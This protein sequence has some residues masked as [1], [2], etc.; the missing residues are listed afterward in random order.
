MF[1]QYITLDSNVFSL[2]GDKVAQGVLLLAVVSPSDREGVFLTRGEIEK[3]IFNL[4]SPDSYISSFAL[5]SSNWVFAFDED[6]SGKLY[7][8]GTIPNTADNINSDKYPTGNY[9]YVYL[10]PEDISQLTHS[11]INALISL[12]DSRF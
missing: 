3:L 9:K 12:E 6:G 2:L 10:T 8:Y 11:F 1:S 7:T 5:G 4:S